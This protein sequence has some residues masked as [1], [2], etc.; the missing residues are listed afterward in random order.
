MAMYGFLDLK[1]TGPETEI[2]RFTSHVTKRKE[3][4]PNFLIDDPEKKH[5]APGRRWNPTRHAVRA[6]P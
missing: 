1:I 2:Q 4:W 6:T 3:G 5:S